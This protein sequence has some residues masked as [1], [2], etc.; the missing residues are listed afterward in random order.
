MNLQKS[1]KSPTPQKKNYNSQNFSKFVR[2]KKT[3]TKAKEEK[4]VVKSKKT[5]KNIVINEINWVIFKTSTVKTRFFMQI[6]RCFVS[7]ASSRISKIEKD[8]VSFF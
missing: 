3:Q 1:N 5:R 7:V 6:R 2:P 8:S 4:L